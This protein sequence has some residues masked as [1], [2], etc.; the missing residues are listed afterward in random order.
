[1]LI[2]C[3]VHLNRYHEEVEHPSGSHCQRLFDAMDASGVDHAV[4]LTSYKTNCDR[5]GVQEVL[6]MLHDSPRTS[7]IEGLRWRGDDRSDLFTM[8]ERI[9]AGIVHDV[10][11]D[12]PDVKFIMC[13]AGNPWFVDAAE[14]LYKNESVSAD[15][16]GQTLGTFSTGFEQLMLKRL[17]EMVQ[18]LGDAGR[19]LLY[20]SDWPLVDER[21]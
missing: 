2:D 13:H 20:G 14:V 8:E 6:M 21:A 11:A 1:M 18:Y 10:A 16:S 19:Q 15:L 9:K 5:P 3:H 4:V 12:Y 7:I 17:E